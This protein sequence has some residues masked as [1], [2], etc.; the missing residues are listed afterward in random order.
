MEPGD[1]TGQQTINNYEAVRNR[2]QVT[3][4]MNFRFALA[5]HDL[6]FQASP[7]LLAGFQ[8]S[9]G[10]AMSGLIRVS[11]Q[12]TLGTSPRNPQSMEHQPQ[13]VRPRRDAR[14]LFQEIGQSGQNRSSYTKGLHD[15]T[16]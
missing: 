10:T 6:L 13:V 14:P 3:V 12:D 1:I 11:F 5:D 4:R 8:L 15:Q 16:E 7:T 9:F 2:H